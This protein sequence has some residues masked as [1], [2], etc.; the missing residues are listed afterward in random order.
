MVKKCVLVPSAII[1]GRRVEAFVARH[2]EQGV[3]VEA[4][5]D[6]RTE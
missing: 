5:N 3:E 2:R 6:S 4:V 1:R